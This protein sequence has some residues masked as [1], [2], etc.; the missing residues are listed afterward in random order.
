MI[1]NYSSYTFSQ[2]MIAALSGMSPATIMRTLRDA[3]EPCVPMESTKAKKYSLEDTRKIANM[4]RALE[5]I[6]HR[7]HVFYN[8]KGGTGKTSIC[9]QVAAHLSLS[10]YNVLVIDCDPQGHLSSML[11]FPE[12]GNFLTMYDVLIN[13]IDVNDSIVSVMPGLKAIPSN[14]TLSRV[15][16][17]L[18]QRP[19]REEKL[20]EALGNIKDEYDFI[21]I[22]TN[23]SFSTLNLNALYCADEVNFVCETAPFSLYGLRVM[24]SETLSFFND[25]HKSLNYK[26]IP[27]K[28]EAKTATAQEVLGYL[29]S[30]YKEH[31]R[32]AVVRKCEDI[33]IATKE[34]KPI[35][36]FCKRSSIAFEDIMDLV[37][38]IIKTS[39]VIEKIALA[40]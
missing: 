7:I 35:A 36:A 32:D 28:Y 23:P 5:K 40:I 18:S 9:S 27:N 14:L 6:T 31:V 1:K 20:K 29:R 13:G 15:E 34:K 17:P 30:N 11:G 4:A 10:G 16:V 2:N 26:I 3:D 33:N 24:L 8:L 39:K 38:E 12:D 21:L 37:K 25:M 22:D 19:R